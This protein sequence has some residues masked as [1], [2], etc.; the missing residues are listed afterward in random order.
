MG[1]HLVGFTEDQD[2]AGTEQ[3][4]AAL[5]DTLAGWPFTSGDNLRVHPGNRH[6][7][8]ILAALD[9]TVQA[10][11][12]LHSPSIEARYGRYLIPHINGDDEPVSPTVF[13]DMRSWPL[14]L[15]VGEDLQCFTV[16]NPAAATEQT[17]LLW[18][19]SE[20]RI[21][22][23]DP[24]GC[25][26]RRATTA[27]AAVTASRWTNRALTFETALK[28]GRYRVIAARVSGTTAGTGVAARFAFEGQTNRPGVPMYD[29]L[30]DQMPASF[31]I[32]GQWG[33]YGEFHSTN[34][35]SI[36]LLCREADNEA[37]EAWLCLQGPF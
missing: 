20:G 5:P 23:V 27:A 12:R 28:T 4:L 30:F 3:E 34:P 17:V 15:Q 16:N 2:G 8:G 32:P 14:D 36:D 19:A 21:A 7:H 29:S 37:Q 26:W 22:P 9:E 31:M 24:S 1:V 6:V 33:V 10:R 25:F 18:A 11:A 35:L 13:N